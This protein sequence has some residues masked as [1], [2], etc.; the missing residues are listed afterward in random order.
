MVAIPIVSCG[1]LSFVPSAWVA[2]E[3]R[4]DKGLMIRSLVVCAVF[5]LDVIVASVIIG[6]APKDADGT[7]VAAASN[8]G[9]GLVI[10]CALAAIIL[11]IVQRNPADALPK[12][13]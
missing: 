12:A 4:S 7:P 3:R 11:A 9:G 10:A 6:T 8:V 2:Y 5:V 13:R 1:I